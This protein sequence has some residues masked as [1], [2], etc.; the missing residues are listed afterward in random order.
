MS[1]E[2]HVNHGGHQPP[3]D[4]GEN[5]PPPPLLANP[6]VTIYFDGLIYTAYNKERR[7]YQGAMLI[8]AEGHRLDIEVRRRGEDEVLWPV[9]ESDWNPDHA[10]VQARAPFWLYVDSGKGIVPEEFS[11]QLHRP[12][13]A[14]AQSF[15]NI[16]NFE[17]RH[18][19]ML[20]L[21][22]GTFAEFNF[23]HGTCYSAAN[24]TAELKTLGQGQLVTAAVTFK[25]NF[26]VSTLTALDIDA[27]SNGAGKKFIVL[28]NN[29]GKDEF[30]RLELEPGKHYEINFLNAPI[31]PVA[32]MHDPNDPLNPHNPLGHFLQFY[33]LFDLEPQSR[34]IVA[35]QLSTSLH[36]PPCVPTSGSTATG[37]GG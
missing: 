8:Q 35:P 17:E 4:D 7:L 30:F 15:D 16:F 25:Q 1:P 19:Q 5:P 29:K 26:P 24:T 10:A 12:N 36:S 3:V 21:K 13:P 6:S 27:V 14:N 31:D 32:A 18:Q 34:F 20:P 2:E 22:P 9:K 23:P 11:A 33:E 28:A 37:L